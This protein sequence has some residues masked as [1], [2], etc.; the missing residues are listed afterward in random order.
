MTK[1]QRSDEMM[2]S[3]EGIHLGGKTK[4]QWAK[5]RRQF[6]VGEQSNLKFIYWFNLALDT[7]Y[8][9]GM[10]CRHCM[11]PAQPWLVPGVLCCKVTGYTRRFIWEVCVW[12]D[13]PCQSAHCRSTNADVP[14]CLWGDSQHA[15]H[16]RR[17]NSGYLW[18]SSDLRAKLSHGAMHPMEWSSCSAVTL[19]LPNHANNQ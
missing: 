16:R 11:L 3:F 4:C 10:N 17:Q 14:L 19:M 5:A 12:Y 13:L 2:K 8:N 1:Q 9:L 7:H 18:I 6:R 15:A